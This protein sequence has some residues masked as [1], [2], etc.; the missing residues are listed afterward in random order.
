MQCEHSDSERTNVN[1]FNNAAK[2][3]ITLNQCLAIFFEPW[4]MFHQKDPTMHHKTKRSIKI[5]NFS[6]MTSFSLNNTSTLSQK[7]HQITLW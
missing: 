2:Y 1:I 5:C 3:V 4:H 7:G 6:N